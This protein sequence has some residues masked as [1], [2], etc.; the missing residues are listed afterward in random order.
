MICRTATSIRL[1]CGIVRHPGSSQGRFHALRL[2]ILSSCSA[3]RLRPFSPVVVR[4]TVAAASVFVKPSRQLRNSRDA[5]RA[6]ALMTVPGKVR[7]TRATLLM[8]RCAFL[9][10]LRSC[11]ACPIVGSADTV[12]TPRLSRPRGASLVLRLPEIENSLAVRILVIVGNADAFVQLPPAPS[13]SRTTTCP[14]SF[15]R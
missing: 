2:V 3:A 5:N 6:T 4:F 12:S 14:R 13:A 7:G 15:R 11:R 8:S 9:S 10:Q 1:R